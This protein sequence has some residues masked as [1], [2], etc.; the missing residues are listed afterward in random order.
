MILRALILALCV[1]LSG[2]A[3]AQ[4]RLALVLGLDISSSVNET[5]DHQQRQGLARALLAPEVIQAIFASSSDTIALAVF[6]WSGRDQQDLILDWV[7]LRTPANLD[8]AAQTIASST[9]SYAEF[10]T[11]IGTALRFAAAKLRQR[12]DCPFRT[13]DLS[14]DGI[15][16]DGP[17][18]QVVYQ[19]DTLFRSV[20]VN[21][22]VIAGDHSEL[23]PHYRATVLH[24]P[25]AFLEVAHGFADY[26]RAM[27]RKLLREIGTRVL[28]AAQ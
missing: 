9:R 5:E 7:D 19:S 2:P 4:C 11:A 18:P 25:G 14:G 21:G 28:G 8:R 17:G 1:G 6:E 15:H 26:E 27:T 20:T 13:V 22:L 24:G 12:Q 16:N 3:A 23:L 10:P